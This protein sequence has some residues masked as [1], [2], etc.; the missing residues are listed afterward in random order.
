MLFADSVCI[1]IYCSGAST[2]RIT[3]GGSTG[4][5]EKENVSC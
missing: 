5:K 4:G 2:R 1:V 3:E